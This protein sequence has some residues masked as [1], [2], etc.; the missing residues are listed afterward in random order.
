MLLFI[1][2]C[3]CCRCLLL[4]ISIHLMLL[5]IFL[6]LY[7]HHFIFIISI[8]LMLL[9]IPS[10]L[11]I[12]GTFLLF[13]YISCYCLSSFR[14]LSALFD[15]NFNTSHVTVYLENVVSV[16][17]WTSRFQYISCYCLS[18]LEDVLQAVENDFNTSHVTV[19]PA[20]PSNP[21]RSILISIHLMLLFIQRICGTRH[22]WIVISIHLMLLFILFR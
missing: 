2:A 18:G 5:F 19:Y 9:F 8:H 4:C 3:L 6:G 14:Y 7:S 11:D 17:V 20:M 21:E 15:F 12:L 1:R 16:T 13:Q 10:P 22:R